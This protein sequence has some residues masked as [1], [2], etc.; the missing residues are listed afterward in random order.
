MLIDEVNTDLAKNLPTEI[1][2]CRLLAT[3][4]SIFTF[5]LKVMLRRRPSFA[6]YFELYMLFESPWL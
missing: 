2:F 3:V 6:L 1:C 5:V 4:L